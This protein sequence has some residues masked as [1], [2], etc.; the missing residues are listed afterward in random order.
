MNY[1]RTPEYTAYRNMMTRCNNPKYPRYKDHGGRGIVI[2]E[3]WLGDF[4]NFLSDMGLRPSKYHSL[5]R[6]DN[7]GN[8][9]PN[10][11]RWTTRDIQ[12]TNKRQTI[13][14]SDETL[15]FVKSELLKGTSAREIAKMCDMSASGIN[16][17]KYKMNGINYK[18]GVKIP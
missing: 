3:R 13:F 9:E 1:N 18:H 5:D 16:H 15:A 8:Y 14:Y 7:D 4:K 6:I 12:M 17:Y 2:C 10:N 11:C